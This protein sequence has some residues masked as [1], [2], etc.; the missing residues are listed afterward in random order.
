MFDHFV[1]NCLKIAQRKWKFFN[2]YDEYNRC[3]R[4]TKMFVNRKNEVCS[5]VFYV[6][7]M[8]QVN[9][10]ALISFPFCKRN[11]KNKSQSD[12][13]KKNCEINKIS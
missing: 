12:L 6:G 4:K 10:H 1:K 9:L 5:V 7:S 11:K 13:R 3:A 8:Y 2:E